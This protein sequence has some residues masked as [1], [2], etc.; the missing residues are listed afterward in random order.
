MNSTTRRNLTG[1]KIR[2][3][4]LYCGGIL[5]YFIRLPMFAPSVLTAFGLFYTLNVSEIVQ[6]TEVEGIY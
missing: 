3:K 1:A 5:R 4:I 6:L 2:R